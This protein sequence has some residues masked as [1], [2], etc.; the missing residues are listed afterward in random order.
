[1][2]L[3][4][5]KCSSS[6]YLVL[7]QCSV[8]ATYSPYCSDH[9]RDVF[10]YCCMYIKYIYKIRIH[11]IFFLD[12]SKI[13]SNKPYSGQ[14]RL[15]NGN[16]SNQGRLEVYCNEQW[17]TVCDDSFTGIDAN[18]ACRQLGYSGYSRYNYI[19]IRYI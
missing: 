18:V 13:W 7:L 10:V 2:L 11:Y 6:S 12:T 16:Y 5:I 3:E 17:G 4:D 9:I 1:M 15:V 19:S 8:S 14:L